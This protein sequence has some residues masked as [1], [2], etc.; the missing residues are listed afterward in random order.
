MFDYISAEPLLKQALDIDEKIV[1]KEDLDYAS[2]LNNLA[3]LYAKMK[4]FCEAETLYRQALQIDE[5][6]SW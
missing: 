4:R 1:G 3:V 2:D 5:K 6:K